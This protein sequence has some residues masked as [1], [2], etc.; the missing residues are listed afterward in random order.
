MNQKGLTVTINAAKGAIPLSAATPV[1]I[2][3][4]EILQ[5]A[6][7]IEEAFAIARKRELFVSES[8]LVGSLADNKAVII[9]KTPVQ[10]ALYESG[11][12][13]IV[14]TNHFQSR[15]LAQSKYN[16]DNVTY[17]DSKYRFDR[18]SQLI[19]SA[20]LMDYS[21][22]VDILRNRFGMNGSDVGIAN[23]MTVN[24]SICH[25]SVVFEPA[26]SLMWVSTGPWQS[27]RFVCYDLGGFFAGEAIPFIN[28][29]F[30][31]AADS[32][33]IKNDLPNLVNYRKSVMIIR[34][35]MKV[36]NIVIDDDF[37]NRFIASNPRHYYTYRVLG[38]YFDS[39][40]MTEKAVLAYNNSLKCEIPYL[41]ER[42]EIIEKVKKLIK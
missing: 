8:I 1:S 30:E 31:V 28:R 13:S 25:H 12:C 19:D 4:R 14:C 38:D 20:G 17:S 15:E 41:N 6:S 24:Q 9:E 3:I 39:R 34:N 27:G 21:K 2:L 23:E 26:R 7:N 5:Y 10:T 37:I 29:N 35:A 22:A 33:F 18:L 11:N 32:S 40:G 42:E 36:E 16:V